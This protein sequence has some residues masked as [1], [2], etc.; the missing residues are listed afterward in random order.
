ML[1]SYSPEE[2][3][4]IALKVEEKGKDLYGKL[5][6]ATTDN[7]LK[8]MWQFLKNQEEAHRQTFQRMLDNLD[9]FIVEEF[10]RGEYDAYLDAIAANYVFTPQLIDQKSKALFA[11]DIEA[12][13]FAISIEKESI[14]VYSGFK[15]Y[16][17]PEKLPVVEDI[18]REEEQH[19]IQLTTFKN[20]RSS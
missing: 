1:E 11:S 16:L 2:I 4:Q 9:E 20:Q 7:S 6:S 19:F 3:L 5:E 13:D 8:E 10:S 18:I 14:F 17:R 12:L 15:K